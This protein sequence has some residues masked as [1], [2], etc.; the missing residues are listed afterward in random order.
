MTIG[1]ARQ[2]GPAALP[3]TVCVE[4]VSDSSSED[5]FLVSGTGA[6]TR[7]AGGLGGPASKL[8]GRPSSHTRRAPRSR[9]ESL[10]PS[11]DGYGGSNV[12][13]DAKARKE[14]AAVASARREASHV[15]LP[16]PS[17][18]S[19]NSVGVDEGEPQP[20]VEEDCEAPESQSPQ[21]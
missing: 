10:V 15:A 13:K 12:L 4:L 1:N 20:F 14:S 9:P 8:K 3:T 18:L 6:C 5:E 21:Q 11:P 17:I 7:P 2:L 19:A 16:S